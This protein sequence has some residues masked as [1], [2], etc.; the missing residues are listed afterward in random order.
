MSY[1]Y[2]DAH[3]RA[4]AAALLAAPSAELLRK[5]EDELL[6]TNTA[7]I[8]FTARASTVALAAL[9]VHVNAPSRDSVAAPPLPPPLRRAALLLLSKAAWSMQERDLDALRA[10]GAGAAALEAL[11]SACAAHDA[12]AVAAAFVTLSAVARGGTLAA[13]L[14]LGVPAAAAV[15]EAA[16]AALCSAEELERARGD[17]CWCG[18]TP[19][20][21]LWQPRAW[22][23]APT[24]R[25]RRSTP[26]R[27]C[28]WWGR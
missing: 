8:G 11:A 6:T 24:P 7:A 2:L 28:A 18:T 19:Q 27:R 9:S 15:F 26:R 21:G 12:E 10:A 20:A 16:R 25:R 14:P 23:C 4:T 13:P 5:L 1:A 3:V 17:R 22:R